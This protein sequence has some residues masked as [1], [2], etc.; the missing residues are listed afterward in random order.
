MRWLLICNCAASPA[1]A[2]RRKR[3]G[4]GRVVRLP[5]SRPTRV[6]AVSALSTATEAAPLVLHSDDFAGVLRVA[7]HLQADIGRVTGDEPRL[8]IGEAPAGQRGRADRHARQE[9]A[10]RP[11]WSRAR[12]STSP[13]IAGKWETFVAA[14]RRRAVARASSARW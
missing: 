6:R 8:A 14:S 10:H 12:S 11:A 3:G 2:A 5:T 13:A 7:K 4:G 1:L 9:S